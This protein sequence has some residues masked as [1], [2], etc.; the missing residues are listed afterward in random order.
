MV[1]AY[2]IGGMA[3]I[4]LSSV[5]MFI[6]LY[7]LHGLDFEKYFM[8]V[9]IIGIVSFSLPLVGWSVGLYTLASSNTNR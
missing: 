5:G 7:V 1:D 8:T 6:G 2:K 3:S 4:F 9:I